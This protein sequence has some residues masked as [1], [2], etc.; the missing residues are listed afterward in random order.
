MKDARKE[1]LGRIYISF[2]LICIFGLAILF[3][4]SRIQ[5]TQADKNGN[6]REAE[7]ECRQQ[8]YP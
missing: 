7:E 1:I 2:I 8:S 4:I 6:R 5:F 3:Q